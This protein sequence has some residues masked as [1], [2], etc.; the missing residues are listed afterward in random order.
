[1]L[2]RNHSTALTISVSS[3]TTQRASSRGFF[4]EIG[5]EEVELGIDVAKEV[6]KGL[7]VRAASVRDDSHAGGRW[8]DP[9]RA[10]RDERRGSLVS[11]AAR[12]A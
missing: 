2:P 3:A 5:K 8:F 6:L 12:R 7:P 1:V 4:N 9:S 10:H 11:A